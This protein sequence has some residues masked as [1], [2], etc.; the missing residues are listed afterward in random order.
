MTDTT[1]IQKIQAWEVELYGEIY[2][3]YLNPIFTFVLYKVSRKADAEDITGDIFV[4]ALEKIGSF[5]T[6]EW[7]SFKSWLYRMANNK[8]ID[9]YRKKKPFY[10][11]DQA[12]QSREN[13]DAFAIH[14]DMVALNDNDMVATALL[15]YAETLP[16]PAY[17]IIIY[18][19]RQE[20]SYQEIAPLVEK[21]VENCRKIYSRAI[22]KISTEFS[23]RFISLD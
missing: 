8:V 19:H 10:E 22:S 6:Y 12:E 14:P 9:F 3:K 5:D 21:S 11:A 18:K 17:A 13:H 4:H 20:M 7:S 16:P 15:E 2:Q 1:T 23:D